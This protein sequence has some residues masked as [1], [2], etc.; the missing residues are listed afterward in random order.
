MFI[1]VD[2]CSLTSKEKTSSVA[3]LRNL[4]YLCIQ[5][6]KLVSI[7]SKCWTYTHQPFTILFHYHGHQPR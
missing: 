4:K 7:D 5:T 2:A 3:S 1:M 6:T